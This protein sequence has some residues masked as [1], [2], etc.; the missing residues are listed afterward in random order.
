MSEHLN[1]E[2][3]DELREIME[4]EFGSLIETFLEESARQF[5]EVSEHW[6][7]Q[8]LDGVRRTAH[9]LKGS[10]ANV[11]AQSMH[12]TCADLEYS[13]RDGNTQAIPALLQTVATD[14]D[15]VRAELRQL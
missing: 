10:C 5:A 1:S 15:Q 7:A 8:D 4:D 9:S 3:L 12:R 11:G 6:H 2:F 14:L 13:A